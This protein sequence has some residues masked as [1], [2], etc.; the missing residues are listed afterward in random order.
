MLRKIKIDK[1]IYESRKTID[2][3]D[4]EFTEFSIKKHTVEE[5]FDLYQQLFYEIE[6]EG[7]FSH[8]TIVF[9][10]TEY[11]DTPPN[12][13][14]QEILDLREQVV[15][16]QY[17]IDSIE[18]EHAFLPNNM[19]TIQSRQ[20][21]SLRY[22]IQSGKRRQ[23]KNDEVFDLLKQRAGYSKD[24]PNEDF[25]VLLNSDAIAGISPGPD[26]NSQDDL[27]VDIAFIN[28]FI[29]GKNTNSKLGTRSILDEIKIMI[30]KPDL[31]ALNNIALPEPPSDYNPIA[32]IEEP[33]PPPKALELNP[34]MNTN[35]FNK[36]KVPFNN[37]RYNSN[38]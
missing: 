13:K 27:S 16:V 21:P 28:R 33:A 9:K 29:P 25:S 1:K 2:S 35:D 15:D 18:E 10:S 11:A 31:R 19:T 8:N 30:E 36:S 7:R 37:Y 22:H 14:D 4:E 34:I 6:K 20:E 17:E 24:T 3:L 26:I 32:N 38:S 12:P 5:F 23:I